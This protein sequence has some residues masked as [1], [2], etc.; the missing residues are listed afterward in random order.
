MSN[1]HHT[2]PFIFALIPYIFAT[3]VY[4]EL[5]NGDTEMFFTALGVL[6]AVR[7]FFS[8][9]ETL[10]SVLTW[11][12][13][14][15]KLMVQKIVRMFRANHFPM[16][17]YKHE[18]ISNYLSRIREDDETSLSLK[19]ASEQLQFVFLTYEDLGVLA[20]A[21]VYSAAEDA[22]DAYSPNDNGRK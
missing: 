17:E 7:L 15:K 5:V 22:L 10:G 8:I 21:R 4:S 18:N 14:G 9:S 20:G 3:W 11:R 2:L 6:L 12:L 16:R 13:Y 1:G 19:T